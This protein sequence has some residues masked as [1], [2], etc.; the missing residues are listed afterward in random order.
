M[1]KDGWKALNQQK[2]IFGPEDNNKA[3]ETLLDNAR[4]RVK[5]AKIPTTAEIEACNPTSD[6]LVMYLWCD[7]YLGRVELKLNEY[8]NGNCGPIWQRK[9]K[10]WREFFDRYPPKDLKN[11]VLSKAKLVDEV[12]RIVTDLQLLYDKIGVEEDWHGSYWSGKCRETGSA[13]G[14]YCQVS[15]VCYG[16]I[17]VLDLGVDCTLTMTLSGDHWQVN[18]RE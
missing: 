4:T 12:I 13:A 10:E 11:G 17:W 3:L 2:N 7:A 9:I 16:S 8:P 1:T 18:R 15:C 6:Q 5:F 14:V